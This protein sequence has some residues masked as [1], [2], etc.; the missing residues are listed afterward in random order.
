MPQL[1]SLKKGTESVLSKISTDSWEH[2]VEYL[3]YNE[4]KELGK[5]NQFFN[6]LGKQHKILIKFFKRKNT[7]IES[8]KEVLKKIS[9]FRN[10]KTYPYRSTPSDD[11]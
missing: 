2:V 10:S 3:N 11:E 6:S 1:I 5:T 9:T 8:R 7:D 4:V